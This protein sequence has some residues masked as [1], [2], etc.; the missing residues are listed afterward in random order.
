MAIAT[1]TLA[2]ARKKL[3]GRLGKFLQGTIG[4]G[5]STTVTDAA[6]HK[7][8][9]SAGMSPQEIV[10]AYLL[11]PAA[12]TAPDRLRVIASF[13]PSTGTITTRGP[14]YADVTFTTE[15]YEIHPYLDPD[16]PYVGLIAAMNK[17]LKAMYYQTTLPITLITDG[18]MQTAG[19]TNWTAVTS[20]TDVK[21]TTAAHVLYGTQGL[22]VVTSAANGYVKSDSVSVIGDQGYLAAAAFRAANAAST[23]KLVVWDVT[24]DAEIDSVTFSAVT[25]DSDKQIAW[26]ILRVPFAVPS[27]CKQVSLRLQGVENGADLYWGAAWL[28][29]QAQTRW[30]LPSWVSEK[31]QFIEMRQVL[32]DRVYAQGRSV[33]LAGEPF[34]DPTAA[35]H[36]WFLTPSRAT[37]L[38]EGTFMRPYAGY[39]TSTITETEAISVDEEWFLAAAE[40]EALLLCRENA[41]NPIPDLEERIRQA[42]GEAL[43]MGRLHMRPPAKKIGPRAWAEA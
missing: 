8:F 36:A 40:K 27:T 20:S 23:A 3:A 34:F 12:A 25:G 37:R 26:C 14:V 10:P 17:A 6:S 41:L 42:T 11:R 43:G 24:N 16:D 35:N 38:L 39:T 29:W 18:D 15:T 2:E 21:V 13:V 30:P 7:V 19:V 1:L 28:I 4:S 5:T 9:G 33:P 31:T 32:G 22:H